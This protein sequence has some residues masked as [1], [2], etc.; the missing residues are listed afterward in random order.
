M[1][2]RALVRAPATRVPRAR[3]NLLLLLASAPRQFKI[4]VALDA[5][6]FG[7]WEAAS[8]APEQT[9]LKELEA[10]K[11]VKHV[12]TQTYTLMPV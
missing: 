7:A 6:H 9:I 3:A 1:R 11:G 5:A 2:A 8:F 4:I 10:V 12:E